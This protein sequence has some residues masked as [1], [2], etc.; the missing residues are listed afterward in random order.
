MGNCLRSSNLRSQVH[1]E[2]QDQFEFQNT[3]INYQEKKLIVNGDSDQGMKVKIVLTKEEL[4]WLMYELKLNNNTTNGGGGRFSKKL[5]E[6]LAEIERNRAL[7][8]AI[9]NNSC[10]QPS[11]ESISEEVDESER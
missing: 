5:E 3:N 9:S 8:A 11:L 7:K 4:E 1:D 6:A 2:E 10:W